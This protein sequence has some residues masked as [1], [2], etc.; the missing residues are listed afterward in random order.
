M[1]NRTRGQGTVPREATR[2]I[3]SVA[4]EKGKEWNECGYNQTHVVLLTCSRCFQVV[5]LSILSYVR[6]AFTDRAFLVQD[7]QALGGH[8]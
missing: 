7:R 2:C 3:S 8:Y 4:A 6:K 5:L 1:G